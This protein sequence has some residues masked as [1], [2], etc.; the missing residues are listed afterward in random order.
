MHSY[1]EDSDD[2]KVFR[3]AS[4]EF[5]LRYSR[6]AMI[7]K[8]GGG[9]ILHD[10][11]PDNTRIRIPGSWKLIDHTKLEISLSS[12]KKENLMIEVERIHCKALIIKKL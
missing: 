12:E 1:E 7:F 9:F 5:P 8:E 10:I 3:P 11:A 6:E 2:L 4:Y